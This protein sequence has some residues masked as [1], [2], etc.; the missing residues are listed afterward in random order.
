MT[1]AW[2][3]QQRKGALTEIADHVGLK[4]VERYRKIDLEV[5]LE[6]HLRANSSKL[7]S[8]SKVA[9]FFYTVD[10]L[11]P[12]KQD[13]AT[14][15]VQT[16]EKEKKPRARRQTIKAR[17][18]LDGGSEADSTALT[19]TPNRALSFARSVPLPTSPSVLANQIDAHASSVRASI[20]TY[21]SSSRLPS[22]LD[23]VRQ[24]LST[25]PSIQLLTLF[26]EAWGL[27]QQVLPL[28]YLTTIPAVPALGT[29]DLPLKV[30]D[31]FALLTTAFWGPFGLWVLTSVFL[32]L[33]GGWFVNLKGEGGYDAVSFNA[34]KAI[35]AWVVYVR[36]GGPSA[37]TRVVEKGVPGGGVGMLVGAGVGALAGVY[38]AVLRK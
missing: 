13:P 14:G 34:V 32:P 17:E 22:L 35:A 28:R 4:N 18:E 20:S 8:D 12:V 31:F 25:V 38:E 37:S 29:P 1:N 33:L 30:P 27:R 5:A 7:S 16:V 3:Q 36:G 15:T 6:E 26:I 23:R 9:P 21:L 2:L 11:S 24:N 10:P 19:K